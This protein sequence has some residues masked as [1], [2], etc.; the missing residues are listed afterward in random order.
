MLYTASSISSSSFLSTDFS[1]R[2]PV[3]ARLV[4]A[5]ARSG[6]PARDSSSEAGS[7]ESLAALRA[8]LMSL[9]ETLDAAPRLLFLDVEATGNHNGRIIELAVCETDPEGA[10]RGGMHFRCNPH[11]RSSRS[12]RRVHG[13]LDRE[14]EHCREFS[15]FAA[16][17]RDYLAGGAVVIHDR[18]N[19]LKWLNA[20]FVRIDPALPVVEAICTVVDS[21]ELA[22]S[23][24]SERRR[25][26]L[27]AL[28]E[29]YGFERTGLTHDAW[30]DARLLAQ[31]FHELWWDLADWL[32]AEDARGE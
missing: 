30:S 3:P 28:V 7:P 23:L 31:V 14:L 16:E 2:P 5:L 19:D 26:G 13:I 25:N 12:A 1:R 10:V 17:L 24:P 20:E 18:T 9:W 27:D 22:S 6:L 32:F 8:R 11:M 21:L 4:D 29:W 15:F